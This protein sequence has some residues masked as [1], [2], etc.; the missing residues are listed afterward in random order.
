MT[1]RGVSVTVNYVLGLAIATVVLSGIMIVSGDI[2]DDQQDATIR[3]ELEVIG[4]RMAANL[5]TADRLVQAGGTTVNV[6][7]EAPR[8]VAGAP[9][10]VNVNATASDAKLTLE[11]E[12]PPVSVEV[13][14]IN[15]TAVGN[16]T[17]GGGNL[18]ITLNGGQ[19]E[20][21]AA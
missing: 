11:T 20:V 21:R 18:H 8:S 3:T 19:L 4:E 6:S 7:A 13:P 2:V 17:V 15:T 1:E 9:Y 12:N 16:T 14:F 10:T 5:M